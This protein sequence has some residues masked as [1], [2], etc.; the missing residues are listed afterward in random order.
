M[1]FPLFWCFVLAIGCLR[2][3]TLVRSLE[4][5]WVRL[6]GR[7]LRLSNRCVRYF[8]GVHCPAKMVCPQALIHNNTNANVVALHRGNEFCTDFSKLN[9][10]C[11]NIPGV[12]F[13]AVTATATP[14]KML[15][16]RAGLGI[17]KDA[18]AIVEPIN[19]PNLFFSAVKVQGGIVP[20]Q[21]DL[22]WLIPPCSDKGR[23]YKET[24]IAPTI[25]YVDH[26]PM[27]HKI[28]YYLQT[29]LPPITHNRPIPKNRWDFDLRSRSERIVT[30][31]HASLSPTMKDY[32]QKDWR[33]G[34]TRILV[35]TSAWGMGIDDAHVERVIQWKA[36][37][38][39]NLD[40]LIQRFG[41][42][43]RNSE[44]Q[45]LCVL[46]HE[47]DWLGE[48]IVPEEENKRKRKA[49]EQK[50]RRTAEERRGLM[51]SGLYRYINAPLGCRR[52]IILG[53]YA[54]QEYNNPEVYTEKCCDLCGWEEL[55]R[56]AP[57]LR[58]EMELSKSRVVQL[59][60]APEPLQ[61]SIRA[62]LLS[63]CSKIREM[64]YPHAK[65]I[66]D[67]SI[68]TTKQIDLIA[69]KCHKVA[70]TS[71]LF[72]IPTLILDKIVGKYGTYYICTLHRM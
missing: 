5:W 36:S 22:K 45:G 51:E 55:N 31:Y 34:K 13:A 68:L 9:T 21:G 59:A 43:A 70:A 4:S 25:I 27:A 37:T 72:S 2:A 3:Q 54:D 71:D 47:K 62:Y 20:A 32:I 53:Y 24:E 65:N 14:D 38:L 48:R 67:S 50:T 63:C 16:I 11:Y 52:K 6:V 18:V 39:P 33:S 40:T 42:C 60:N 29:F 19:R 15:R 56:S 23:E 58:I 69:A 64:E 10:F 1:T 61:A 17:P 12:P 57:Q 7:L 46:Y 26:K 8:C 49:D 30:P 44:L 28:A 66:I 41:R 35:A